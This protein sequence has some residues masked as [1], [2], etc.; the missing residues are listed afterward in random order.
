MARTEDAPDGGRPFVANAVDD[1]AHTP[2]PAGNERY[3]P[4]L[5][6]EIIG[7]MAAA[8]DIDGLALRCSRPGTRPRPARR[9]RPHRLWPAAREVVAVSR[10]HGLT[11]TATWHEVIGRPCDSVTNGVHLG[12]WQSEPM[13]DALSPCG[14]RTASDRELWG[15]HV[16]QK[17]RMIEFLGSRLTRQAIRLRGGLGGG[18]GPGR[19]LDLHALTIGFARR[20]ATYKRADLILGNPQ[21]LAHLLS[22]PDRPVQL[23]FAGKAH[24]ADEAGQALLGRVVEASRRV[25]IWP[26]LLCRELRPAGGALSRRRRGRG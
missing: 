1:S 13:R 3:D 12:T 26:D 25:G 10:L 14:E 6:E 19:A 20:S 4:A 8:L 23:I 15:A 7:P 24:P 11:A 5:A 2:V 18:R 16:E 9:L 17:R 22:D 21:R